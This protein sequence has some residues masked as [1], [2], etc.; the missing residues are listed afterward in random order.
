MDLP[1]VLDLKM[2]T[3]QH[4]DD[5]SEE[6]RRSH[7]NKCRTS[8]SSNLGLRIC[9]MQVSYRCQLLYVGKMPHQSYLVLFI[10]IAWYYNVIYRIRDSDALLAKCCSCGVSCGAQVLSVQHQRQKGEFVIIIG[11]LM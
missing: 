9:G 5:V 11:L 4:G 3:R 8:T 1:C 7:M 6:K 2:G 10:S